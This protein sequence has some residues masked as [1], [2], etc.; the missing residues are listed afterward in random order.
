MASFKFQH[1]IF[2]SAFCVF[3]FTILQLARA[4]QC[5]HCLSRDCSLNKSEVVACTTN[6]CFMFTV[7]MDLTYRECYTETDPYYAQCNE[8][9]FSSCRVCSGNLCNDWPQFRTDVAFS[10]IKCARGVCTRKSGTQQVR[11]CPYF[12]NPELPRCYSIVDRYTNEYTFGCANEMTV[13]QAKMCDQDIFLTVCR[14]CDT[15]NCNEINFFAGENPAALRCYSTIGI[16]P[17]TYQF[18]ERNNNQFPYYGC[19]VL[20]VGYPAKKYGCLSDY[21]RSMDSE[22]YLDLFT[23]YNVNRS[24]VVCHQNMCNFPFVTND[25]QGGDSG[26]VI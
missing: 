14:Y 18:C 21:F 19:F 11:T 15:P 23:E 17:N 22:E 1:L 26:G 3:I 13:A 4:Q 10:C 9:R 6:M 2:I 16:G 24:M 20:N 8:R 25:Y 7:Q 12:R 5:Y